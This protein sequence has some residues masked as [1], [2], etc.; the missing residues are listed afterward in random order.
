MKVFSTLEVPVRRNLVILFAA[1]LFF[2]CSMASLLPTLP[3]YVEDIGGTKQE[4]GTV[5]GGFAIGLLLFRPRLGRMV[6]RQSRKAVLL[7]GI[8]VA[9]IAPLGYLFVKSIPLLIALRAFHGISI[10]AFTTAYS[11][12]VVDLSPVSQRGEIIGYMS[13]VQPIGVALGPAVGGFLQEQVGYTPLFLFAAGLAVVSAIGA[14]AIGEAKGQGG[15]EKVGDAAAPPGNIP[16]W[17]LLLSPRLRIPTLVMLLIGLAFGA[18]STFVPL[19]IR[20][21]K[22][23]LNPGWFYTAAAIASFSLRLFI[24]RAS[25]RYGRGL[26][27]TA[28]LACYCAAMWMLSQANSAFTFLLAGAIEGSGGGI[29]FPMMIALISDRSSSTERGRVFALCVGGFDLGMAIAGP[30]FGS[31]AQQLSY[32]GIFTISTGLAFLALVI[33]LTQSNKDL[34]HSLKFAFGRERDKYAL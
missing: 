21:T 22:V 31:V 9:A 24:G 20:E 29:F 16:F 11:T 33:F 14:C 8:A 23:D 30:A 18:M 12:L 3:G 32:K 19:Y 10:A 13:L 26:F 25:D 2:W 28:S 34:P 4:I 5:M 27:I 1:A 17:R 15:R 6:D 7:L